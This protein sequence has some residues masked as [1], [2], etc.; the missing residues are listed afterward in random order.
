[1]TL[2]EFRA[3]TAHLPGRTLIGYLA[4]WGELSPAVIAAPDELAEDDPV[5]ALL[6]TDLI[7]ITTTPD[8]LAF[9]LL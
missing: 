9:S 8:Q 2:S 6:T 4:P 3:A 1:M 5:K 7:A